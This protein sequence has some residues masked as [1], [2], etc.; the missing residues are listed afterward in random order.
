MRRS[1]ASVMRN[2]FVK[3]SNTKTKKYWKIMNLYEKIVFQ[4]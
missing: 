4:Y 3:R 1:L 2:R